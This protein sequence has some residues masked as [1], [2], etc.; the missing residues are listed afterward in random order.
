MSLFHYADHVTIR[1]L[2]PYI[3]T[4]LC[5]TNLHAC[6]IPLCNIRILVYTLVSCARTHDDDDT[7]IIS[8]AII[9]YRLSYVTRDIECLAGAM[10]IGVERLNSSIQELEEITQAMELCLE[11]QVLQQV[12]DVVLKVDRD[13]DFH[14]KEPKEVK[15][16]QQR[17]SQIPG[18]E[19]DEDN[20][21]KIT[22]YDSEDFPGIKLDDIM[23]MFRNLKDPNV[24][25]EDNI[26]RLIPEEHICKVYVQ[27]RDSGVYGQKQASSLSSPMGAATQK[28]KAMFNY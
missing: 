23:A 4:M 15:R 13:Q 27:K 24:T 18:V 3:P 25:E 12:M 26:F 2:P 14:I 1:K 7:I 28:V 5:S 19:F 16:L 22:Q 11:G 21:R 9:S 8:Y 6:A 10:G 17:L 20:F